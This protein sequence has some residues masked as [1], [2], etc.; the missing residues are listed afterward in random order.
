MT[1]LVVESKRGAAV[2]Q[3][4]IMTP[5]VVE[6]K[7]GAAVHRL[8][9]I[10]PLVVEETR[11]AAVHQQLIMTPLVVKEKLGTAVHQPLIMTPLDM[12]EKRRVAVHQTLINV[13]RKEQADNSNNYQQLIEE[14]KEMKKMLYE[15]QQLQSRDEKIRILETSVHDMRS[16][17]NTIL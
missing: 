17:M 8:L 9:I 2:H 7:Q 1:P 3:Q 4:L 12:E 6:K 11:G 15:Q 14:I 5:L 10:T 16:V 13:S